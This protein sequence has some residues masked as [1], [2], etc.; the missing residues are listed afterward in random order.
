MTVDVVG[1][2]GFGR[3]G[4]ASLVGIGVNQQKDF[5][6]DFLVVEMPERENSSHLGRSPAH[7]P[8][9][10]EEDAERIS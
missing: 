8:K 2:V 10:L 9:D 7:E 4:L 6:T 5:R 1:T 3:D